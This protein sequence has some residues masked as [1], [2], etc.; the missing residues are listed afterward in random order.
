MLTSCFVFVIIRICYAYL[1]HQHYWI[2]LISCQFYQR[3]HSIEEKAAFPFFPGM[4]Y[5]IN[6]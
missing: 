2:R 3:V 1:L 6:N 5:G 4:E